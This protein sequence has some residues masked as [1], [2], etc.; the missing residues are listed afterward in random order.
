M[1]SNGFSKRIHE[2]LPGIRA[3]RAEIEDSRRLPRDLVGELI[4]AGLFRLG[5]PRALGGEELDP[6]DQIRLIETLSSADGSAGWCTMIALGNGLFAG[7]MPELGA[8]EVFANPAL[9]TA[10]SIA[11]AGAAEPVDGG[12]RVGG[13]WRFASGVEHA[14]WVLAG[15]IVMENGAPR[16]TPAGM[17]DI[18]HAFLPAS[19]ITIHDTWYASGLCGTGSQD[20]EASDVFVPDHRIVSVF[21]VARHRPE[22]L[23]RIPVLALFAPHVAAVGLGIARAALDEVAALA[24]DKTPSFSTVPLAEKP[25]TQVELARAEAMLGGARSFLYDTLDDLWQTVATGRDPSRRQHA[26]CRMAAVHASETAGLV[27]RTASLLAGGTSIYTTSSLQRHAR[28]ADAVMHHVT[29][30]SQMWEECGR[31]LLGFEPTF[32][33]F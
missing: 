32:P 9:P 21:D 8:K 27:A 26:L 13:R 28:D 20:F 18:T 4:E 10:A 31:V 22:P 29:Q 33:I 12:I 1:S 24:I 2:L 23:Y 7:F 5:V 11:P 17:P 6:L 30:S 3:R 14:E 19:E 15:C 16:T 25:L